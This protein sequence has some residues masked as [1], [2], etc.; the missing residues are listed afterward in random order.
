MFHRNPWLIGQQLLLEHNPIEWPPP[1]VTQCS[2]DLPHET[3]VENLKE[4]L[5]QE[6]MRVSSVESILQIS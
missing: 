6:G 3:W 4:Y 1:I 2:A 5:K